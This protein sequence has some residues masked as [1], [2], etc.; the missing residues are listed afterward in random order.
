MRSGAD[1]DVNLE[2]RPT[3][4]DYPKRWADIYVGLISGAPD[5]LTF[6]LNQ[7]GLRVNGNDSRNSMITHARKDFITFEWK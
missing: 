3:I 4:I 1:V 5:H 2:A 7:E 6:D